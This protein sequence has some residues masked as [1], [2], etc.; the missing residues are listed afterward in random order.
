MRRAGGAK[1]LPERGYLI[2]ALKIPCVER[3]LTS[4]TNY[5][6]APL[7]PPVRCLNLAGSGRYLAVIQNRQPSLSG[8][9][10][11]TDGTVKKAS[12]SLTPY[13]REQ[14]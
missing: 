4:E 8:C 1:L 5:I 13:V 2:A 7:K 10:R 12:A 6:L 3:V 11:I 14:V 9:L